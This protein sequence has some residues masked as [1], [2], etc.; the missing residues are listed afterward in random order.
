MQPGIIAK[1]DPQALTSLL[2]GRLAESAFWIAEG[3]SA[4]R[5]EQAVAG[6]ELLLRGLLIQSD[7]G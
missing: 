5:L 6:L 2:Y 4:A 1:I 3:D 7:R